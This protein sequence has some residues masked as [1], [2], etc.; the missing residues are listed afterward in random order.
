MGLHARL[1]LV[2]AVVATAGSI[3]HAGSRP[4]T[5]EALMELRGVGDPD[6]SPDGS[7]VA[8]VVKSV[9]W[10]A[11][12]YDF[13]ISITR[14]AGA[15]ATKTTGGLAGTRPRWSPDGTRLAFQSDRTGVTQVFVSGPAGDE[16]L[17]VT[18]SA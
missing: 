6:I 12:A 17:Q 3:A 1:P 7:R 11:N 4:W 18:R 10:A 14:V 15:A 16:P 9:D 2:L 5:L 8:Y 13:R